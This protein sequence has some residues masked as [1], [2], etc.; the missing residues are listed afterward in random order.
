MSTPERTSGVNGVIHDIGYQ[1]YQGPRLGKRYAMWSLYV[2][3]LRTAFGL[4]RGFRAKLLPWSLGG[5]AT[6]AGLVFMIISTQTGLQVM[7]YVD[8]I[9]SLSYV[10]VIFLAVAAPEMVSRDLGNTLMPLYLSRPLSSADYALSKLAALVSGVFLT[11]APSMVVM[12][13]GNA[14]STKDGVT[15]VLDHAG[16]FASGIAAVAIHAVV[17]AALALPLASLSGRRIFASTLVLAVFLISAPISQGLAEFSG[18]PEVP[19]MIYPVTLLNGVDHWL[20][21]GTNADPGVWGP[22]YGVVTLLLTCAAV[23]LLLL[24]YRKVTS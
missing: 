16:Q 23:G 5:A 10:V 9:G 14:F 15:G 17:L 8:L 21:G 12:F 4:G 2:H 3:S 22:M 20:L 24:R 19:G 18:A 7:G 1:R 11:L 6:I 13:A